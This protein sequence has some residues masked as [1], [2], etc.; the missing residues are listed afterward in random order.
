MYRCPKNHKNS[1]LKEVK[2]DAER[3]KHGEG[4]KRPDAMPTTTPNPIIAAGM[5]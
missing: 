1:G 5:I 3:E 4:E 2:N